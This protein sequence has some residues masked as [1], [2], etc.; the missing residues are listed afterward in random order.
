LSTE[1][2]DQLKQLLAGGYKIS[3]EHV[4]QRRFRTGSWTSTGPIEATSERQ[5]IAALE[6]T[7]AEYP[8][9]YVRLIG[10]DPKA[11][12]RVLET[13]IQRP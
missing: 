7:L 11:K 4:D 5:A 6:A 10:I 9:E 12:R 2:V 1:V 3:V 13:I 8:G